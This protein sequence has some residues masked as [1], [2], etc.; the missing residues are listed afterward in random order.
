MRRLTD[1]MALLMQSYQS[2]FTMASHVQVR[3]LFGGGGNKDEGGAGGETQHVS[4]NAS[5]AEKKEVTR[6]YAA[7]DVRPTLTTIH[8]IASARCSM[9]A[10]P[11]WSMRY[12]RTPLFQPM[13]V[14]HV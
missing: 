9:C 4:S 12:S 5:R 3:G 10:S 7:A 14:R 13:I 1:Y 8:C 2:V 6:T 11:A